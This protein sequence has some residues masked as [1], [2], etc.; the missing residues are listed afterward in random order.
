MERFLTRSRL[1]LALLLAAAAI[2]ASAHPGSSIVVDAQG[3]VYFV[4]TGQGVWKLDPHGKLTLLHTLAYHWMA[5]DEKGRFAKSPA[6][7]DFDGGS[8]ERITPVGAIPTLIVS[9][10]YP[11]AVGQDGALYYVPY[12]KEGPREL[13]R[14][15][16][17]GTRSVFATLPAYAGPKPMQWVNGIVTG[18]DGSLYITDNDAVRK[19]DG[20]G[21]V[22]TFRD[23]IQL[24]DCAAPLPDTPKLPY[25]RGLAVAPD[26][27][28]FAAANGCR[29]VIQVPANGA[30]RTISR[31][32]PPWSPT[33]VAVSGEDVYILEYL[34]TPGDNRN[35]W[36]PRVRKAGADGRITTLATI[37]RR[38]N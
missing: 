2:A 9:S 18:P 35:E 1:T 8:F 38:K 25:L 33:G 31:S 36:T 37:E 5:L 32:E 27:T 12:R 24:A 34:H 10:D 11:I 13:V 4:D 22:S 14:K 21:I 16:P 26:G 30:I 7:G 28:V 20:N 29:T 23:A 17:D 19:I 3:Q 15:T 6:L